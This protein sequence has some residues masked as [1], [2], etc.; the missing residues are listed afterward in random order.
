MAG[1]AIDLR[2]IDELLEE[3]RSL[4]HGEKTKD[5]SPNI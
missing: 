2:R 3:L 1:N 4:I 5:D